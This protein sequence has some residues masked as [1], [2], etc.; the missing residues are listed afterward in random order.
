MA[1][2]KRPRRHAMCRDAWLTLGGFA[3]RSCKVLDLSSGGA[4]LFVEGPTFSG[5]DLGL[6][7]NMDIHKSTRCRMV[8]RDGNVIGV[9]FV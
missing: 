9:E 5:A 4:K 1:R 8:W 2:D 7:L 6:S 3:R